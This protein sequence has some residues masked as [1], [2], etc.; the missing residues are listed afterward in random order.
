[1]TFE[2]AWAQKV[3][4]GY[5]YGQDALEQVRFGWEIRQEN[6]LQERLS[7]IVSTGKV[8]VVKCHPEPFENLWNG[9]KTHELRKNDRDYAIG[10]QLDI[11]EWH[12]DEK[13]YT[14]RSLV[15]RVMYITHGGVFG[16]SEDLCIMSVVIESKS[17]SMDVVVEK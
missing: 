13:I 7:K 1:M 6:E 9:L 2:E 12:P 10:D 15:A 8:H 14:R 17:M 16:L 4:E 5:Q 11:R 3:K